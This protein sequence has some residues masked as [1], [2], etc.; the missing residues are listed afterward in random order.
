MAR[1]AIGIILAILALWMIWF[2]LSRTFKSFAYSGK[3]G[4]FTTVIVTSLLALLVSCIL[5]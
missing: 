1:N 2:V 3:G 5:G 4:C